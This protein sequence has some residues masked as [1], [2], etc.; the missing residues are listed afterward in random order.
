[1]IHEEHNLPYNLLGVRKVAIAGSPRVVK[2]WP[3]PGKGKKPVKIYAGHS[4]SVEALAFSP[5]GKTLASGS[6]DKTVLLWKLP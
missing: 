4:D 1:M 2:L 3:L 6:K 5:D